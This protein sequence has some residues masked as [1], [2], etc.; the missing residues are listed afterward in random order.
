LLKIG[1]KVEEFIRW[2]HSEEWNR[3]IVKNLEAFRMK[4]RMV[5]FKLACLVYYNEEIDEEERERRWYTLRQAETAIDYCN[6]WVDIP[7]PESW[8]PDNGFL[9]YTQEE[10]DSSRVLGMH[11]RA[12]GPP[13]R[14]PVRPSTPL[15]P[16]QVNVIIIITLRKSMTHIR[17]I[18]QSLKRPSKI[19]RSGI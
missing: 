11:P 12:A 7:W 10:S 15:G 3:V 9:C 14:C 13:G 6:S 5:D 17:R 2:S 8:H 16:D 18:A 4:D 1:K 19:F